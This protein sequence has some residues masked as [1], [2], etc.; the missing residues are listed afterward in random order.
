M[1]SNKKSSSTP[2][3][4]L[5]WIIIVGG[6]QAAVASIQLV[7]NGWLLGLIFGLI[8][9]TVPAIL[10]FSLIRRLTEKGNW[11][12][13]LLSALGWG[14]GWMLLWGFAL[15]GVRA[16]SLRFNQI[17]FYTAHGLTGLLDQLVFLTAWV[18][19][20]VLSGVGQFLPLRQVFPKS[21]EL[22][23]SK[24]IASLILY[25]ILLVIQAIG[26]QG[27]GVG[28]PLWNV[29]HIIGLLIFSYIVVNAIYKLSPKQKNNM[30]SLNNST[31]TPRDKNST[32]LS[33]ILTI[34][35][36]LLF[37]VVNTAITALGQMAFRSTGRTVYAFLGIFLSLFNIVYYFAFYYFSKLKWHWLVLLIFF[38]TLL[39]QVVIKLVVPHTTVESMLQ[40]GGLNFLEGL[41]ILI[42]LH[43]LLMNRRRGFWAAL[44]FGMGMSLLNLPFTYLYSVIGLG[45]EG[46]QYPIAFLLQ[47]AVLTL[48]LSLLF[49]WRVKSETAVESLP[50]P[51]SEIPEDSDPSAE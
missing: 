51:L 8:I 6:W 32:T 31:N 21:V 4:V 18:L 16:H 22:I 50:E 48:V 28:W 1:E 5:Y 11:V 43:F 10:E 7:D 34:G 33:I 45:L 38:T 39:E 27:G 24:F 23:K 13:L 44:I 14:L 20:A 15:Y 26:S 49:R 29:V 12:S 37:L 2:W 30:N 35:F 9:G 36:V 46:M 41:L 3:L 40:Y 47:N 19:G 17:T 42:I 25:T